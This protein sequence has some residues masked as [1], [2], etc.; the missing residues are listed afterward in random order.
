MLKHRFAILCLV[1]LLGAQTAMIS[2]SGAQEAA[3][4]AAAPAAAPTKKKEENA[5]PTAKPLPKFYARHVEEGNKL[6]AQNRIQAAMDEFFSAKTINPDYYP[7]YIGIGNA[8]KMMGQ[9]KRAM[10]NYQLAVKLLNPTYATAHV[11]LGDLLAEKGRF[12]EAIDNYWEVLKID[13]QAGNQYSLALR[14][15]RFNNEKAAIKAFEEAAKLDDDYP[16]PYFQMGNVY[17]KQNKMDKAVEAYDKSVELDPGNPVY[18]FYAGNAHYTKGTAKKKGKP[19]MPEVTKA[20]RLFEQAQNLGLSK[21]NLHFNLG[22]SYLLEGKYDG[23]IE[24]LQMTLRQGQQDEEVFFNLGNA[25]FKRAMM[26]DFVWDGRHSLTNPMDMAQ[27]N[28]KFEYMLKAV[29]SYEMALKHKPDYG[30][31]Y[32]DL[33]V[34]YYRLAELKPT[35]EFIP[36]LIK[37]ETKKDYY[38]KGMR[39]FKVDMLTRAVNSFSTYRGYGTDKKS[40]KIASDVVTDIQAIISDL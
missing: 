28:E 15:L 8:Y 30:Q 36:R 14:H 32:F 13:P 9:W 6:L 5:G 22:T 37:E 16:D 24:Q 4:E 10:E 25:L 39:F 11:K 3:P 26:I 7:T 27:N 38:Q 17:F 31:V 33:G 21:P 29:K 2:P 18:N 20:V 19:D 1:A 40:L 12:P 35:A 23:A 34:A